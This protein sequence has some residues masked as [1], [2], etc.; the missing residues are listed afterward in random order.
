MLLG[1]IFKK[2]GSKK[3]VRDLKALAEEIQVIQKKTAIAIEWRRR[4]TKRV[5][6]VV[7]I[8][9]QRV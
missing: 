3:E 5:S 2:L 1:D 6:E 9:C 8:K 4:I 7:I